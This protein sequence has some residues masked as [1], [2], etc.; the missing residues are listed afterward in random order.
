VN[1]PTYYLH[2]TPVRS[3]DIQYPSGWLDVEAAPDPACGLA[4][5]QLKPG[6][7]DEVRL[8]EA[9]FKQ[10]LVLSRKKP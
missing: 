8:V 2:H 3:P 9:A 1:I 5:A 4:D 10:C 6:G 7:R